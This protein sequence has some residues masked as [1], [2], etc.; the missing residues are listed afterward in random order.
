MATDGLT[1]AVTGPTGDLGIA[2]VSALERSRR[3]KKIVG[4]ARRP[5]DPASQGWKKTEYRQGDVQDAKSVRDA[6]KG[7]DVVV[8]LAFAIIGGGRN[9]EAINVEGSRNVFEAAIEAGAERIC[10]ASSVAAYG[11][12]SDNP[13]WLTEDIPAR[14]SPE[15]YYSQQKA[16]VEGVLA[17]LLLK[18]S[19]TNAWV[20][21]PC[22]VAGPRAQM[23]MEQ[24]PYFQLSDRM[25]DFVTRALSSMPFLKPVIPDVGAQFQFV[26]EDDVASAFVAG[27]LGKGEPGPYNLAAPGTLTMKDLADAL[28]WYTVPVPDAAVEATAEIMSRLPSL[29]EA[30]AWV[31]TVRKPVLMKTDRAKKE[32]GWKPEHTAKQT[33]KELVDAYRAEERVGH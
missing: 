4:M 18:T 22:I 31:H 11:F 28:D 2:L 30:F 17:E 10:Y 7:A 20:F 27:T 21:R 33:L 24:I 19:R 3:V 9:S 32:L 13:D 5:F 1:V 12:H 29:P 15:M 25:P 23:L 8:H 16:E 6:V 14:G 26:H